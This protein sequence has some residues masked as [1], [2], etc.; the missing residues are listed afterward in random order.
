LTAASIAARNKISNR[1]SGEQN[2]DSDEN[3]GQKT[4]Q[5]RESAREMVSG[6]S[7]YFLGR[8]YRLRVV[9]SND[10]YFPLIR[11]RGTGG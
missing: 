1:H 8:R 10:P 3:F 7:H 2:Q 6:E 11:K 9:C 4:Q 5:P